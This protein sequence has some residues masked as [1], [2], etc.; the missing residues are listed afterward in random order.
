MSVRTGKSNIKDYTRGNYQGD[1]T[2]CN[3]SNPTLLHCQMYHC[4]YE[5]RNCK[6]STRSQYNFKYKFS[7]PKRA[8]T[9]QEVEIND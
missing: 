9:R 8:I 2:D 1:H 3:K 5:N 6:H 4:G 7:F